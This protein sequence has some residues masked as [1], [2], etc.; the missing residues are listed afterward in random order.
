MTRVA[1]TPSTVMFSQFHRDDHA[2]L[3]PALSLAALAATVAFLQG[4]GVMLIGS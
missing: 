1:T 3:L 4:L 2:N